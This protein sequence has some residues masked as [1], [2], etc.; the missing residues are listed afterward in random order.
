MPAEVVS[1][2]WEVSLSVGVWWNAGLSLYQGRIWLTI[3]DDSCGA[4]KSQQGCQVGLF[5]SIGFTVVFVLLFSGV[6]F[7]LFCFFKSALKAVEHLKMDG[8]YSKGTIWITRRGR[9]W[10]WGGQSVKNVLNCSWKHTGGWSRKREGGVRYRGGWH[11]VNT[12]L[13][14][15]RHC[16]I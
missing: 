16:D 12:V 7:A 8:F 5:S 13:A 6:F 9:G 14:W 1:C 2:L 3:P 10:W 11:R 15:G 4:F